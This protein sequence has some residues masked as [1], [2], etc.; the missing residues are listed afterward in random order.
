MTIMKY[1]E[2]A[3]LIEFIGGEEPLPQ[4]RVGYNGPGAGAPSTGRG[5]G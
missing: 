3:P 2:T 1:I 4:P 5:E